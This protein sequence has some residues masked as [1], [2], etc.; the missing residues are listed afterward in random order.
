MKDVELSKVK[1]KTFKAKR[2]CFTGY[3]YQPLSLESLVEAWARVC[4][5]GQEL[6]L[7]CCPGLDQVHTLHFFLHIVLNTLAT[8]FL[9]PLILLK[10]FNLELYSV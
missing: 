6:G 1:D 2:T 5:L 9:K 4:N 10:H 7:K 8:V 3:L